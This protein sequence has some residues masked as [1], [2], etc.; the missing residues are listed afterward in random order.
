M[1]VKAPEVT[2]TSPVK[3]L[4]PLSTNEPPAVTST[5]PEKLLLPESTSVPPVT[6]MLLAK[7]LLPLSVSM[8]VP[9]LVRPDWLVI[10]ELMVAVTPG[11]VVI[12]GVVPPSVSVL[13]VSV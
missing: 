7:V 11:F 3:V 2:L 13:P 5:S 4:A 9:A 12:V 8:P 10:A 6:A 1:T